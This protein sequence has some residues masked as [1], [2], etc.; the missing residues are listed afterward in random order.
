MLLLVVITIIVCITRKYL[1]CILNT[2]YGV[3]FNGLVWSD[4]K[5]L[6]DNW[7]FSRTCGKEGISSVTPPFSHQHV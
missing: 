2:L 4:L 7:T 5:D 1:M 3:G 6:S